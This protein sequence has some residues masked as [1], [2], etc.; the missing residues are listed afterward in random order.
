MWM[1]VKLAW[2]NLFRNSRRTLIA[3]TAIGIGLAALI[4]TDALMLG[5]ADHL[6]HS[7]TASYMGEAQIHL[8]GYRDSRDPADT[9]RDADALIHELSEDQRVAAY[10]PRVMAMGTVASPAEM[11]PAQLVGVNPDQEQYVSQIDDAMQEGDFLGGGKRDLVIGSRMAELLQ[12][13]MGDRVVLTVAQAG[14]GQLSQELFRVSGI[15]RFGT[16]E[17]DQGLAFVHRETLQNMLAID[18]RIHEIALVLKD[19][20]IVNNQHH[21]FFD[22]YSRGGNEAVGW[23]VLFPQLNVGL[24]L[25]D[26]SMLVVGL[27][28]FGV[29]SLGIVNTLFMSI[30]ERM[31]E[32]GVLRAVGTRPFQMARLII[33]EAGALAVLSIVLGILLGAGITWWISHVGIDY[34][35]I[36]MMGVTMREMIYPRFAVSQFWTYPLWVLGMT[37]LV[38]IYPAVYAARLVP[39]EAIRKSL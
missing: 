20:S 6:I 18:G 31:F 37:M 4:F 25:I 7:A 8:K 15:Y 33:L 19:R 1:T 14:S 21:P 29:V 36:E 27:I 10:S 17:M 38:G 9:I 13:R 34:R 26:M 39:A 2:R 5:M 23:Q 28:L 35:G 3:G 30:Y 32:F 11:R 12:V 22:Q 24:E 16:K